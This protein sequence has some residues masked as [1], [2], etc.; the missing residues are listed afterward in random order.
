VLSVSSCWSQTVRLNHLAWDVASI[1]VG[2]LISGVTWRGLSKHR[3][4]QGAFHVI[5]PSR[6]R[7]PT[8]SRYGLVRVRLRNVLTRRLRRN[9]M[10]YSPILLRWHRRN[11]VAPW[12]SGNWC[13]AAS[14]NYRFKTR[15]ILRLTVSARSIRV[16][17]T[18]RSTSDS[19]LVYLLMITSVVSSVRHRQ[20]RR[21]P[22]RKKFNELWRTSCHGRQPSTTKQS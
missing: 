3:V 12:P 19:R 14:Q 9:R 4:S 1:R 21:A 5:T 11:L 7:S 15:W 6:L 17:T 16:Q 10:M 8:R 2:H 18:P 22:S 13:R 20:R